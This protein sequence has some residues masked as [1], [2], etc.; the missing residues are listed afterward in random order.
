MR[1]NMSGKM[2]RI[3]D[4][5]FHQLCGLSD[6]DMKLLNTVVLKLGRAVFAAFITI[7]D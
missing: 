2:G 3:V 1:I 5:L 6:K 7:V 4:S